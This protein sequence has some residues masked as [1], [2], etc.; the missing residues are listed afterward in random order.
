MLPRGLASGGVL[1]AALVQVIGAIISDTA[2]VAPDFRV[3]ASDGSGPVQLI[4]DAN[5]PF[6]RT[7]FRPGRS[8]NVK[9]VLVPDGQG[10]WNLKP[11]DIG[12]VSF[13]N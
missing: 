12:D 13:N 6:S 9:G 3:T 8:M 1:D 10:G 7:A 11:R 5:L 4:L 2:T